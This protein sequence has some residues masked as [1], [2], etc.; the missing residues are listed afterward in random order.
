MS[1]IKSKDLSYDKSASQPAFLQRLRDQN[2]AITAS[3][4]QEQPIARAQR[5]KKAG[6][7]DDDAP[8]YVV[9]GSSE[10]LTKAEY[11]KLTSGDGDVEAG[12]KSKFGDVKDM[13]T[14]ELTGDSPKASGALPEEDDVPVRASAT[15][16]AGKATKKRKVAKVVGGEDE[17]ETSTRDETKGES[18]PKKPK[19]KGKPIKLSFG[20]EE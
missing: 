9:E 8:T 10:T 4:R 6:D 2:S 7:D 1:N 16:D 13:V 20:D 5:A 17:D 12:V 19:K 14:G 15:I 11:E 18:N 3:G